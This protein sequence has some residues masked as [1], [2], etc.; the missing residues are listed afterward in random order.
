NAIGNGIAS[1]QLQ[2][3]PNLSG[4]PDLGVHIL[5]AGDDLVGLGDHAEG[6]LAGN[7]DGIQLSD[8][9]DAVLVAVDIGLVAV[10]L[11]LQG[12]VAVIDHHIRSSL[13]GPILAHGI[14]SGVHIIG[15]GSQGVDIA[16]V[17]GELEPLVDQGPAGSIAD[18]VADV[19][20]V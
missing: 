12:D 16:V 13:D 17:L 10:D 3:S 1:G 4:V 9:V 20:V 18:G 2:L 5:H 7:G 11:S 19:G 15:N 8:Q 6:A 14:G